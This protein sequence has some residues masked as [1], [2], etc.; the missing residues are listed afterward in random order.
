M[1]AAIF[2]TRFYPAWQEAWHGKVAMPASVVIVAAWLSMHKQR[3]PTF[4]LMIGN[5]KKLA[6]V[7]QST[8]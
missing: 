7:I 3:R 2:I 1:K 6:L 4:F 8:R 5:E